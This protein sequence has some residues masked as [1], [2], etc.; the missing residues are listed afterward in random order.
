MSFRLISL[1]PSSAG[2]EL[3]LSPQA[4][5]GVEVVADVALIERVL[6]NLVD[7]ACVTRRGVARSN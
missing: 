5:L 6:N 2:I 7:N 3:R 4:D 1:A